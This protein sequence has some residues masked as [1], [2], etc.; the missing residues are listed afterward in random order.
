MKNKKTLKELVDELNK[1]DM[2]IKK[3]QVEQDNII[4][5]LWE[6]I[7]SLKNVKEF[8]PKILKK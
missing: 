6:R 5:E 4:F 8:Q 3:I 1:L 7:P 2:E